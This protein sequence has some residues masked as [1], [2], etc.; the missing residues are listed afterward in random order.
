MQ[1]TWDETDHERVAAM[2]RKFNKDELLDMDFNVYLASSSSEEEEE[3]KVE[4]DEE[5]KEGVSVSSATVKEEEK[6][7]KSD[8]QQQQKQ[9]EEKKKEKRSEQQQ[10][11]EEKKKKEKRSEQQ[12]SKYRELLRGLQDK[13]K[14]LQEDRDM[15]MEITWVPGDA[16][17]QS[18]G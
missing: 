15:E 17:T 16:S 9:Q 14:K 11:Q 13:E 10:Q 1:L 12:I 6:E 5:P 3:E 4:K 7:K 2:S 8:Q 18:E